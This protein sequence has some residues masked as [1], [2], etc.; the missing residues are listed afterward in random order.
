MTTAISRAGDRQSKADIIWSAAVLNTAWG[1]LIAIVGGGAFFLY[2]SYSESAMVEEVATALPWMMLGIPV[3][4]ITSTLN[5]ALDGEERFKMANSLQLVGSILYQIVPLLTAYHVSDHLPDLI[6]AVILCR[7]VLLAL[8]GIV[9]GRFFNLIAR[10]SGAADVAAYS[11][12]VNSIGRLGI[13]PMAMSRSVF[14]K[15][16]QTPD[17]V[18]LSFGIGNDISFELE[19]IRKFN[20]TVYAFD[21]TPMS[22][23]WLKTQNPPD[24]FVAFP[25]GVAAV[26]GEIEFGLP[27]QEG[28]DSYSVL[29]KRRGSVKCSVKTLHSILDMTTKDKEIDVLKMD[30]EGSE[31]EVLDDLHKL[32]IR[33][34]QLLIEF[35]CHEKSMKKKHHDVGERSRRTESRCLAS[36]IR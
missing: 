16:S 21:P 12:A 17:L 25:I 18:V 9:V 5:G 34:K 30:I 26:D 3:L 24:R 27:Q 4:M 15:L 32:K 14:P 20:A 19:L 1:A 35:H 23:E 22:L 8:Y 31:F 7:L 2:S 36:T 6:V 33:P 29:D 28:W 13:L 10:F 11:I